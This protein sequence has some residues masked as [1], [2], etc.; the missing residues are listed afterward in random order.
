M[1]KH[2]DIHNTVIWYSK[3]INI[4]GTEK[5]KNFMTVKHYIT[6]LLNRYRVRR[7]GVVRRTS[8]LE[9]PTSVAGHHNPL[10]PVHA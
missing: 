8:V 5:N 3:I 7:V 1:T 9:W 6:M 10:P 4:A 2:N